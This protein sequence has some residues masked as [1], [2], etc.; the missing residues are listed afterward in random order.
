[1]SLHL[2][3][4]LGVSIPIAVTF[5]CAALGVLT[6]LPRVSSAQGPVRPEVAKREAVIQTLRDSQW[7]RL[8]SPAFARREGQLLE[9]SSREL[10]LARHAQR[11]RVPAADI[12]SL[13]VRGRATKTG[14]LVGGLVGALAGVGAGLF[15]SQVICNN[16]D[17]DADDAAVVL[18]LGAGG[19]AGGA[20]VGALIGSAV[21]KWHLRF[22]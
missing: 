18:S 4:S 2:A 1:M 17:C 14:A 7:V 5:A 16:P 13:W 21:P 3:R 6:A 15:I 10:V 19:V 9:V 12:D 20:L 11:V 8:V 22:P